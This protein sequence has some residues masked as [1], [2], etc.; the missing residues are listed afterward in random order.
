MKKKPRREREY[1]TE[2]LVDVTYDPEDVADYDSGNAPM[3]RNTQPAEKLDDL[4]E[5]QKRSKNRKE[6]QHTHNYSILDAVRDYNPDAGRDLEPE[7]DYAGDDWT[8]PE[9]TDSAEREEYYDRDE[10]GRGEYDRGE[11]DRDEY[12]RDGYDDRAAFPGAGDRDDFLGIDGEPSENYEPRPLRPEDAGYEDIMEQFT[13]APTKPKYWFEEFGDYWTCSCGHLNKGDVCDNCGLERELLR[14]LFVLRKPG[15][16]EGMPVKYE[17]VIVPKGRLTTKHKL[18]IASVIIAILV[19]C[20]G[21]FSY[22]YLY[23]PAMEKE[24]AAT[25]KATTDAVQSGVSD[26][27]AETDGFLWESYITAGD[28]ALDAGKHL[29]AIAYYNKAQQIEDNQDLQDKVLEAKYRYVKSH[30]SKGGDTFEKFLGELMSVSYK[31]A[32]SIYEEYYAWNFKVVANLDKDDYSTD[33]DTASRADTVYF[34]VSVSGGPPDES[35]SVY[36][37]AIWPS[38]SKQTDIIGSN[39]TDGSKGYARFSY[40]VPPL[41][42]EGTLKFNIYDKST[43]ELLA[44][45][46]IKLKK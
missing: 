35:V 31:E 17:E 14:S 4:A 9:Y 32:G 18:I 34:H 26:I 22:Y 21:A 16:T 30:Q 3:T 41:G 25:V 6:S 46:S 10:Y 23:V 39:W 15:D 1:S 44:S 40:P 43:Q 38:G 19:A 11:Y 27:S 24:A 33:I 5:F 37:E 12:G 20:G 45:D 28:N 29:T 8:E 7:D 2:T 13:T 42:K 36:Y